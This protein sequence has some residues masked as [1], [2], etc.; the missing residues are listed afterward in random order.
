[1]D[2]PYRLQVFGKVGCKKCDMLKRRVDRLLKTPKWQQFDKQYCDVETEDGL[3]AF[4]KAQCVNPGRIPAVLV[5]RQDAESGR[6]VPVENPK[7]GAPDPVC[8]TSRLY[9]FLGLQ[10][11]Y[12]G[13]GVLRP[14]M[15]EQVMEEA[16]VP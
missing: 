15:V 9:H 8:G 1:M 7:P 6:Y 14:N 2:K 10:T 12:D 4:A 16:L 11:D 3:V 13:D 5:L